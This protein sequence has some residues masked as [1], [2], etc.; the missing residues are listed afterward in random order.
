MLMVNIMN[1]LINHQVK[2]VSDELFI[3]S[4]NMEQNRIWKGDREHN[5][6]D[7]YSSNAIQSN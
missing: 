1:W 7:N 4:K 2:N 3:G 6:A 5:L